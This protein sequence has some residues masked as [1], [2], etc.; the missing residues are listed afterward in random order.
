ME[1]VGVGEDCESGEPEGRDKLQKYLA[2]LSVERERLHQI[3]ESRRE[4]RKA[5][6]LEL[7]ACEHE[8]SVAVDRLEDAKAEVQVCK[9]KVAEACDTMSQA[10]EG[11]W[12]RNMRLSEI[13]RGIPIIEAL[14]AANREGRQ[15]RL[16]SPRPL[17]T[18]APEVQ[19]ILRTFFEFKGHCNTG[20]TVTTHITCGGPSFVDL[21][22]WNHEIEEGTIDEDVEEGAEAIQNMDL[23]SGDWTEDLQNMIDADDTYMDELLEEID[24]D[25]CGLGSTSRDARIYLWTSC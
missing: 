23:L 14:Q 18:V 25:S 10:D 21:E 4:A 9:K 1:G 19:R 11:R 24:V 16:Y 6:K 13:K 8:L 7:E 12:K 3:D 5:A 17:D 15:L 2:R 22:G 20:W